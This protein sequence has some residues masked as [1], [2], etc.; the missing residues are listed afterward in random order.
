MNG[1]SYTLRSPYPGLKDVVVISAWNRQLRASDA[2]DPR[3]A[4]FLAKFEQGTRAPERGAP[5][6]GGV[7]GAQ[8][9]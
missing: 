2:N 9:S 1:P 4:K 7:T 6:S 8:D 3:L 5:C